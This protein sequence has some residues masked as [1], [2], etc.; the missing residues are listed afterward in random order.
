MSGPLGSRGHERSLELDRIISR[1]NDGFALQLRKPDI[2]LSP[3]KYRERQRSDE[4]ARVDD[5]YQKIL[6]LHC[7]GD[8]RLAACLGRF[9]QQGRMILSGAASRNSTRHPSATSRAL[10]QECLLDILR[11][12]DGLESKQWSKR[13]S[14]EATEYSPKRAR[15]Q[16]PHS[17]EHHD[18]V[19][20][21]PVRSSDSFAGT[22][23]SESSGS[24]SIGEVIQPPPQQ[25]S[26]D[27]SFLSSRTSFQSEVFSSKYTQDTSFISQTT[28][29]SEYPDKSINYPYSQSTTVESFSHSF[30]LSQSRDN[31]Q[32]AGNSLPRRPNKSTVKL[33]Y[34]DDSQ[35]KSPVPSSS[36]SLQDSSGS[37]RETIA[38]KL[39]N[40][41]RKH[42]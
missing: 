8:S 22:G 41:W 32:Q 1:L 2:T 35:S 28:V 24:R 21:L 11:D 27:R 12:V 19:D 3:R 40:I 14:E 6:V 4:E 16:L 33:E 36:R 23:V 25:I 30:G 17:Y 13:V 39:A 31:L 7:G 9:E 37:V 20:A 26:L 15:G 10:L 38:D 42:M 34:L 29:D 18:A 5:I